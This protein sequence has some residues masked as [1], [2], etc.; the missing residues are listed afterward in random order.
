MSKAA[1]IDF[2]SWLDS[3]LAEA[4]YNLREE[5]FTHGAEIG[6]VLTH[7]VDGSTVIARMAEWEAK[8]HLEVM[9]DLIRLAMRGVHPKAYFSRLAKA[10]SAKWER[11]HFVG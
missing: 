3:Y 11:E 1:S 10:I 8:E 9:R 2:A 4:G 7:H 5:V 6:L